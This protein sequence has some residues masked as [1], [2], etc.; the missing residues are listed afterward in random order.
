MKKKDD[1]GESKSDHYSRVNAVRHTVNS[2]ET[3][4][5]AAR[6]IETKA[7]AAAETRQKIQKTAAVASSKAPRGLL[8]LVCCR[9]RLT[10]NVHW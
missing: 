7:T 6:Q 2:E 3:S 5:Q 4:S 8:R 10:L 9:C 1:D